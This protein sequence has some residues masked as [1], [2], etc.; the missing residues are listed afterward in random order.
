MLTYF[1]FIFYF[2]CGTLLLHF[3]LGRKKFPFTLYHTT[4]IVAFKLFLGGVYGYIFLNKYGGDDTWGYFYESK[5]LS[6]ALLHHP[7]RFFAEIMPANSLDA[8]GHDYWKALL[9]Y[10]AHFEAWFMPRFLSILNFFT[11]RNYYLD[12]IWFDF[13]ALAGPL[14]LF[15]IA[16]RRYP[17]KRGL[18][19]LL[20]FFVPSITFWC[21]GIRAEAILLFFISWIIYQVLR[22]SGKPAL[23]HLIQLFAG[24][25][26]VGLFRPQLLPFLTLALICLAFALRRPENPVKPFLTGWFLATAIFFATFF[27]PV[28]VR[29]STY[30][31]QVQQRFF[32]L[33]ANT[34]YGLDSLSNDPLSFFKVAPQAMANSS[35]RPYPWEGKGLLQSLS[36]AESLLLVAALLYYL[37]S[38]SKTNR[39]PLLWFFLFYGVSQLLMIGFIVPFPGAIVRYR[40]IP[41]LFLLFFLFFVNDMVHQ[42]LNFIL[43]P[44]TH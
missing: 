35:L 44:E 12:L 17:E 26:G 27:L 5:E 10:M 32:S 30:I 16:Y 40:S 28:S 34:R 3:I 2:V 19:F 7:G 15:K 37:L 36:S 14:L 29:P 1:L 39:D 21:S 9:F 8:T 41:L 43:P 4:S 24:I 25:M 18:Y 20:L 22:Y 38:N 31:I 11:G 42:K 6:D 13:L 23:K 33:K